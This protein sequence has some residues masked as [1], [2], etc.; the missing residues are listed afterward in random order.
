VAFTKQAGLCPRVRVTFGLYPS[1]FCR[2]FTGE[3]GIRKVFVEDVEEPGVSAAAELR[4]L[5]P[6]SA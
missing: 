1:I 3:L 6:E 5:G 4:W 2:P